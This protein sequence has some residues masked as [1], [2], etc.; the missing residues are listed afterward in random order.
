MNGLGPCLGTE[1]RL[2]KWSMPNL[3]T[4]QQANPPK[5]ITFYEFSEIQVFIL[6]QEEKQFVSLYVI[7]LYEWYIGDFQD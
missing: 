6:I 2:L 4:R 1:S 7:V 3:T 5:L